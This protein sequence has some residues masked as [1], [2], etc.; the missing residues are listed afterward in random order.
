MTMVPLPTF[1]ATDGW[2]LE[3]AA[4]EVVDQGSLEAGA[5]LLKDIKALVAE[6]DR[7][8]RPVISAAHAAHKAAVKQRSDLVAPLEEAEALIKSKVQAYVA[9][10]DRKAREQAALEAAAQREQQEE[11][12]KQARE[13]AEMGEH[14]LAEHVR[15]EAAAEAAAPILVMVPKVAGISTP[16]TWHAEV[17]DFK[18]LVCAVA[19]GNVPL[20]AL[21]PNE[22]VLGQQA[23]ALR[24]EL[25]WPGVRV[26]PR[27][28]V[29]VR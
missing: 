25:K 2:K 5:Q 28:G 24:S 4:L 16:E 15:E 17:D 3:A 6:I 1:E 7:S 12:E 11:A 9:E 14:E 10:E 13:L 19:A 23:R 21:L 20:A 26:F 8:T 22:K 27:R 18:A 29:S